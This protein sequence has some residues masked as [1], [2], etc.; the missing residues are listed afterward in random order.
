LANWQVILI[1]TGLKCEAPIEGRTKRLL[2]VSRGCKPL[3]PGNLVSIIR[4]AEEQKMRV[5]NARG[6]INVHLRTPRRRGPSQLDNS[7]LS[8]LL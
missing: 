1:E 2:F 4:D 6:N 3:M 5:K 8:P 7:M